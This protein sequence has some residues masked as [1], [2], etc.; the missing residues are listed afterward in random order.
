MTSENSNVGSVEPPDSEQAVLASSA[1]L[2]GPALSKN[3]ASA[4]NYLA[5]WGRTFGILK[6]GEFLSSCASTSFVMSKNA[7]TTSASRFLRTKVKLCFLVTSANAL[8]SS[9]SKARVVKTRNR[10]NSRL[11]RWTFFCRFS[12][13]HYFI[14]FRAVRLFT[15][16]LY[17]SRYDYCSI[18]FNNTNCSFSY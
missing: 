1:R 13:L 15:I 5:R 3:R 14:C 17:S 18:L 12:S 6:L 11:R 4:I 7:A 2:N 16:T 9:F 10:L 8:F